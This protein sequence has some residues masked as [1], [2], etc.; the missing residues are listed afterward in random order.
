MPEMSENR[1]EL[2]HQLKTLNDRFRHLTVQ[3]LFISADADP[4][5]S[6]IL[7]SLERVMAKGI[8]HD[9]PHAPFPVKPSTKSATVPIHVLHVVFDN[10]M[11][12]VDV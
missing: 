5:M 2:S 3:R 11:D 7:R 10:G 1:Q 6:E 8:E 9:A 4:L 12:R